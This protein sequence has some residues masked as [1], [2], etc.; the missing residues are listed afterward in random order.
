MGVFGQSTPSLADCQNANLGQ[1]PL[2]LE[3]LN[4][5]LYLCYRTDQGLFGWMRLLA[6][7]N[8]NFTLT[9]QIN[10]WALP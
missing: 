2:P 10:T 4:Q 9:I 5:G 7:N 3:Q 1:T 6:L 8:S